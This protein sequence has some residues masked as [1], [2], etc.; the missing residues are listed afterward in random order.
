MKGKIDE[1]YGDVHWN[2]LLKIPKATDYVLL[3][4]LSEKGVSFKNQ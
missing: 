1:G 4:L 3:K 2:S